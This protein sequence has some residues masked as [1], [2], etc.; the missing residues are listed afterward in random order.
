MRSGGETMPEF[1]AKAMELLSYDPETGAFRWKVLRNGFAGGVRP[2]DIA[3]TDNGQG[4]V[5]INVA[6]RI[7][8]AH[9]L[10]WLFMTGDVPP[11]GFEIDHINGERSDNRWSN[12][13][14][15]SR[16]QNN[17]NLG[18]SKRNISGTKGVSWIAR[19]NKWLARLKVDG[20]II[21]LGEFD[22]LSDAVAARKAG[23]RAHHQEFA[24]KDSE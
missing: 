24:R 4:Y 10:A 1:R 7:W 6:Q 14:Q 12:L 19:N 2:G 16:R 22:L 18:I 11:K 20:R 21:H 23:E 13:R 9:R 3:G 15:V 5:Q 8:R 17:Y